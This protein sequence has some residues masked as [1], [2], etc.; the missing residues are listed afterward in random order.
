MVTPPI[1]P[2]PRE[3][4][5]SPYGPDGPFKNL[6]RCAQRLEC[7]DWREVL[8]LLGGDGTSTHR[9]A[10]V[11]HQLALS[12]FQ[13]TVGDVEQ[14]WTAL[15]DAAKG[16]PPAL[17]KV[18]PDTG[19]VAAVLHTATM[20]LGPDQG[21]ERHLTLALAR[22]TWREQ[23]ELGQLRNP[24]LY[25]GARDALIRA[26]QEFLAWV[27]FAPETWRRQIPPGQ[28]Q[29]FGLT[30][31]RSLHQPTRKN[32]CDRASKLRKFADPA[33]GDV[34]DSVWADIGGYPGL[35]ALAL[36]GL[37]TQHIVSWR[38]GPRSHS[39]QQ[40]PLRTGCVTAW[41]FAR[42]CYLQPSPG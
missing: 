26:C 8:V 33:Q 20:I 16:L 11:T 7:G 21:P 6:H 22:I 19:H 30:V 5:P 35:K 27:E 32:L 42:D 38:L 31:P 41:R 37:S 39:S 29:G 36:E 17:T 14:A 34:S 23:T 15:T 18:D 4:I 12:M 3:E 24:H 25:A 2:R 40:I 1:P 13:Q 10:A 28:L 9:L